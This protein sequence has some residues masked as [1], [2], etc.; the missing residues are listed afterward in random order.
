LLFSKKKLSDLTREACVLVDKRIKE[1][2]KNVFAGDNSH[3]MVNA[4]D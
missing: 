4:L 3:Q 1:K 2:K